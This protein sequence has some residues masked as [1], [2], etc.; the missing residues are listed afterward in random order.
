M[1][2]NIKFLVSVN[3]G[4]Q[5]HTNL[6]SEDEYNNNVMP[7]LSKNYTPDQYSVTGLQDTISDNITE[8]NQYLISVS[9]NG[10]TY[11]K[12]YS[13]KEL[14]GGKLTEISRQFPDYHIQYID[15]AVRVDDTSDE[16]VSIPWDKQLSKKL[17]NCSI[18]QPR[19]WSRQT[20]LPRK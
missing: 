15:G 3:D 10:H 19:Q 18:L 9:S 12:P 8:D 1:N 16:I 6:Y 14:L 20:K 11:S 7:L 13:G 5:L 17:D 2:D 4:G